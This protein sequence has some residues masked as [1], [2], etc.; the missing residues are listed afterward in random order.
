MLSPKN[1]MWLLGAGSSRSA[2]MPSATDIIQDLK[3]RYYCSQEN[4]DIQNHDLSNSAIK[5]KIQNFMKSKGFPK[6]WSPE[7]YSFYFDLLFKDDYKSQQ[8][9]IQELLHPDKIRLNAG[10]RILAALMEMGTSRVVFTTN[11][12]NVAETAFSHIT[13]KDLHSFNLEGGYAALSALNDEQYPLYCKIHGDFRYQSIKN[14]PSDL[15][16]ND[17]EIQKCFLAAATRFGLIISGYSGRDNNVME[18]MYNACEQN[19]AFNQG[20]YWTFHRREDINANAV[21]FIDRA[22]KKGINAK[23]VISGTY[24]ELLTKIWRQISDKPSELTKKVNLKCSRDVNI[25]MGTSDGSFPVI[26]T[27]A[28]SITNIPEYC[29][30][31]TPKQQTTYVEIINRIKQNKESF[32]FSYID[33]ILYFG[34]ETDIF[35]I[36]SHDE[37]SSIE[38][39]SLHNMIEE[40]L[41]LNFIVN[42]LENALIQ[43]LKSNDLLLFRKKRKYHYALLN[44]NNTLNPILEGYKKLLGYKDQPGYISGRVPGVRGAI[45]AECVELKLDIFNSNFQLFL[46]PDIWISPIELRDE[47]KHYINNKKK[48]RFNKT[49][50]SILDNWINILFGNHGN[51]S[52]SIVYLS[53]SELSA[54]FE[55]NLRSKY[56]RRSL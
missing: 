51:T 1:Y 56:S 38:K 25:P 11:F 34:N 26:R 42:F 52:V 48:Y 53:G 14:L 22:S 54:D 3:R 55:I 30:A 47:C 33:K 27:N 12:D 20:V 45:W 18:M 19:N 36:Y 37:I 44:D 7:E 17:Q 41:N 13:S 28:L 23:I 24:D 6:E 50:Y 16:E 4:Q 2:G 15:L 9:Y 21:D 40:E 39:I 43:G 31:A 49:A 35:K 46:N 8:K 32:I 29:W 5:A 10:Q